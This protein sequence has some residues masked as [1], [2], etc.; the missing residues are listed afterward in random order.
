MKVENKKQI[1]VTLTKE[2]ILELVKEKLGLKEDVVMIKFDSLEKE[3][4]YGNYV[5]SRI[6]LVLEE[7]QQ[8]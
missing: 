8:L 3:Q 2:D 5:F 4:G 1:S 7:K 6:E